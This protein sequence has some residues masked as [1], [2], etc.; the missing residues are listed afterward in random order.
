MYIK[1]NLLGERIKKGAE[2]AL[3]LAAYAVSLLSCAGLFFF[4]LSSVG[5]ELR[6][7]DANIAQL[8]AQLSKLKV[9]TKEVREL[10]KKKNELAEKIA[11]MAALK[12]KKVGPVKVLDDL[13]ISLPE[14]AW[15]TNIKELEGAV[16]KISG[17]ALD[18]QTIAAF[19]KS[20]D[21]SDYFSNV[22]LVETKQAIVQGVGIKEFILQSKI[23][24]LGKLI[25]DQDSFD[26]ST[27]DAVKEEN[28]QA[29]PAISVDK[30]AR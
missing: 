5:A 1:I 10:D 9:V 15:I 25:A 19:M 6:Q 18:N 22:D 7:K 29:D 3:W 11:V 30:I 14:K 8:E 20:L 26:L 17:F 27:A 23:N 13:N 24:Y 4:L 12:K 21:A 16:L 28:E 2:S